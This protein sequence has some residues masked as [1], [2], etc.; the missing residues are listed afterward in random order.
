MRFYDG[1]QPL[2][3][4]TD[5]SEIRLRAALLQTISGT[6]FPRYNAPDN[7]TLRPITFAS[8][9]M[10]IAKI[11]CSN[12]E[13]EA[14]GILHRLEKFHHYHF[15]REV[16]ILKDHKP[17]VAIFKKDIAML[18]QRIQWI[19]LRVYQYRVRIIYKSGP[20]LS[21]ADLLSR[22]TTRRTKMK[23]YLACN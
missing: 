7:S 6:S 11:R 1:T 14:Q 8:K 10:S 2:Y 21:I 3:L 15:V 13:G 22:Q 12:I 5:A 17:L 16:S 19:L 18:S 20:D 4:E 23:K 9:S